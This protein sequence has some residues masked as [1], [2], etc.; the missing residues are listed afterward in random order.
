MGDGQKGR[1]AIRP[2]KRIN[3]VNR[4]SQNDISG[5][6]TGGSTTTVYSDAFSTELNTTPLIGT[7]TGATYT[8]SGLQ[9]IY[10]QT[11]ITGVDGGTNKIQKVTF[12]VTQSKDISAVP[13][14]TSTFAL[15]GLI[16]SGLLLRRRMKHLR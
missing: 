15:F 2:V 6:I 5:N 3:S 7:Q 12:D 9:T 10:V 14:V 8:T 13:E 4:T 16:S 11:L 1:N